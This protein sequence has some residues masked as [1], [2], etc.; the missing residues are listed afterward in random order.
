MRDEASR[1]VIGRKTDAASL[2]AQK[3]D[4]C[5]VPAEAVE[6]PVVGCMVD[7]GCVAWV[8]ESSQQ[9]SGFPPEHFHGR[10]ALELVHPDDR[11]LITAFGE[12]GWTG[13]FDIPLRLQDSDGCWTWRRVRGERK[14]DEVGRP[15]TMITLRKISD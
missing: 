9:L 10:R 7:N 3:N 1:A 11:S 5:D 6:T 12:V 2:F 15:F 8:S 14:I 4:R 13:V